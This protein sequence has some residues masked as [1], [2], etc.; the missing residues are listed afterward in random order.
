MWCISWSGGYGNLTYMWYINHIIYHVIMRDKIYNFFILLYTS[1]P[2][3][4]LQKLNIMDDYD[5]FGDGI[6]QLVWL[7]TLWTHNEYVFLSFFIQWL[8]QLIWYTCICDTPKNIVLHTLHWTPIHD[9]YNTGY[10]INLVFIWQL[11][12]YQH[13]V[14]YFH[15]GFFFLFVTPFC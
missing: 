3:F 4:I 14:R 2:S 9:V 6:I 15:N 8:C 11:F 10:C 5:N 7:C 13:V 1:I 12:G